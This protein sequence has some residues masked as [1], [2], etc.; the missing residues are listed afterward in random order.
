MKKIIAFCLIAFTLIS[1]VSSTVFNKLESR[2][3]QLKDNYNR[4]FNTIETL[5]E[6]LKE[7]DEKYKVKKETLSL[8]QDSLTLSD[9]TVGLFSNMWV[10]FIAQHS[11]P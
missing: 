10:S 4:Q 2:Y 6:K 11:I 3:A 5:R 1:C 9:P 7:L 8:T